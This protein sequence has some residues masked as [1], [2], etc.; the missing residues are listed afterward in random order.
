MAVGVLQIGSV[1]CAPG[2]RAHGMVDVA[3]GPGRNA[4]G[5]P[6]VIVNGSRPGPRLC[7]G[8]GIHGDEYEGMEA[9]R[10]VLRETNPHQLRGALIGLPCVNVPAFETASRVSMVDHANLNRVFPGDATGSL[11]MRWAAT[12][13]REVIPSVDAFLDLHSGG[14]SGL[15]APCTIVQG[16][17]ES[18][19]MD[20]GLAV[21]H[22]LIWK[23]GRWGGT[24]RVS[25]LQAGKPAVTVEIGGGGGCRE[26]TVDAH[27]SG[28][29]NVMRYL[30]LVDGEPTR[31]GEYK[32]VEGTTVLAA[33]G[34]FFRAEVVPGQM[35]KAKEVLA[36]IVDHFGH[37]LEVITAPRDGVVLWTR[38]RSTIFPG[39]EALVFVHVTRRLTSEGQARAETAP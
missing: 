8:A 14:A 22:E 12:F 13:V 11:S 4:L 33:C 3:T 32:E 36:T 35:V 19:A 20:L 16:G 37:R 2:F 17:Y 7:V 5:F 21:G 9:I 18:L 6:V 23:G 26:E 29:L 10:R 30:G 1:A 31:P 15:I 34:G 28:I 27:V 38:W 39:D 25:S 24:A